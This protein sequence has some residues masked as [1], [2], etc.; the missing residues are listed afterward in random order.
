[1]RKIDPDQSAFRRGG[2]VPSMSRTP[3]SIE[4]EIHKL[5]RVLALTVDAQAM[6]AVEQKIRELKSVLCLL[7]V[8]SSSHDSPI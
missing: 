7:R 5:E 8:G 3:H 2:Y 1:M 4:R 6:A